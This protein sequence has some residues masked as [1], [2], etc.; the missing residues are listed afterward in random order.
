MRAFLLGFAYFLFFTT[1]FQVGFLL[2]G[3]WL[4]A[5][6]DY[7]FI[8]LTV[9]VFFHEYLTFFLFVFE[10]LLTWFWNDFLYFIFGLPMIFIVTMKLIV[11]T[12]LGCWL[13][14]VCRQMETD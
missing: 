14:S 13:L 4:V 8:S 3:L 11:N 10:W 9:H 7:S 2:W 5:T 6:T 12:L 1:P